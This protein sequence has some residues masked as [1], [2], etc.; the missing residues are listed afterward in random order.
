MVNNWD[1]ILS[2]SGIANELELLCEGVIGGAQEAIAASHKG[3]RAEHDR[4]LWLLYR[5]QMFLPTCKTDSWTK[6]EELDYQALLID[7]DAI[8][9]LSVKKSRDTASGKEEQ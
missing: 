8:L 7:I 6:L 3:L 9:P 5:A 2:E 4:L 1:Y